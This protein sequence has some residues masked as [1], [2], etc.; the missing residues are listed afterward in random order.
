MFAVLVVVET[1]LFGRF[2][3]SEANG[4]FDNHAKDNG[5][6]SRKRD[7]DAHAF[8]LGEKLTHGGPVRTLCFDPQGAGKETEDEDAEARSD[9]VDA[10][11]IEGVVVTEFVFHRKGAV[12]GEGGEGA[13]NQCTRGAQPRRRG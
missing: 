4:F 9:S 12:T 2:V 1:G 8:K 3:E 7:G 10:E 13:E 6:N 5:D 11:A